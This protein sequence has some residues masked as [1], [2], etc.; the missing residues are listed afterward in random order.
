MEDLS[1]ENLKPKTLEIEEVVKETPSIKTFYVDC[2][3]IARKAHPGNFVM[4]WIIGADEIPISL[5]KA[6]KSGKL[7]LTVE[8]VGDATAELH[9]LE[10]GDLI[11]IRGPY[12]NGFDLSKKEMLMV[13]GGCGAAPLAYAAEEAVRKGK[14][15]TYIL[16]AKSSENLLFKS[17]LEEY[18]LDLKIATEDGSAGKKGLATD[19]LKEELEKQ[20][21]DSS[22]VCGPELMMVKTVELTEEYNIPTQLSLERYMKCGIGICG[23]C[24][25]DPS[26]LR[27]CK[28]GPVFD[29]EEIKNSEFG[30]YNRN[31]T[32]E[33]TEI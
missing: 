31:S 12:G 8:K 33:K 3:E 21:F 20:E 7:G 9:E 16:A 5:S 26:G 24:T 19:V 10:E 29:Y 18:D 14:D 32:G 28:E 22:L 30:E 4:L 2:P 27:V 15:V 1:R 11:G 25:L 17:R 6:E 13:C 23:Q